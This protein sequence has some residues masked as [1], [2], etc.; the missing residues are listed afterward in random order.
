MNKKMRILVAEDSPTDM[1]LFQRAMRPFMKTKVSSAKYVL[2]GEEAMRS[3]KEKAYDIL[4]LD[5]NM[6]GPTGLEIAEHIKK[7]H[8][9]EK[10][11]ILTGY[12]DLNE[13]FSK[14]IGADEYVEKP[15]DPEVLK[16]VLEKYAPER[17]T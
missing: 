3:I 8:R 4:F 11:V 9:A 15:I 17:G 10:V 6:P 16:V 2:D 5:E 7:N 14:M 12:P 13:K 1:E